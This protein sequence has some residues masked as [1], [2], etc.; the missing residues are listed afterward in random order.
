MTFEELYD[1]LERKY[2]D[3]EWSP[4]D[5]VEEIK[6][7]QEDEG[8][9]FDIYL[10]FGVVDRWQEGEGIMRGW[11]EEYD[12]RDSYAIETIPEKMKTKAYY[13]YSLYTFEEDGRTV[14]DIDFIGNYSKVRRDKEKDRLRKWFEDREAGRI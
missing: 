14:L 13:V 5:I 3:D 2:V 10:S 6:E 7:Y 11:L 4:E 8:L 1:R 9:D 12:C